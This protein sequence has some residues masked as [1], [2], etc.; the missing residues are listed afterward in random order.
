MGV[1]LR[2]DGDEREDAAAS[3]AAAIAAIYATA[4]LALLQV[5]TSAV[6]KALPLGAV[7]MAGLSQLRQRVATV[8]VAAE[9]RARQ[10][11]TSAGVPWDYQPVIPVSATTPPPAVPLPAETPTPGSGVP[12]EPS[13]LPDRG[14]APPSSPLASEPKTPADLRPSPEIAAAT[15]Q[16]TAP[17]IQDTIEALSARVYRQIPDLYQQAI[18]EAIA[19]TRGG[20]PQNSLSLSRIQAA[21]KALDELTDR[22]ITGFTD[23]TGKRWDLLGYVEMATRTAVSNAYDNLQNAALLRGGHDLIY[24]LTHSTEGSCP[25]CIPWLGKL[26][27]L[28]GQSSGTVTISD[29]GGQPVRVDVSGTLAEA[30]AAGFRHPNCRCS[31]IPFVNGADL[32]QSSMFAEPIDLAEATYR[33]SQVQRALERRVRRA[34]QHAATAMTPAARRRAEADLARARAASA[35]H[36]CA[37][38]LRMTKVGAHRREHPSD[39]H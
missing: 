20:M 18:A 36:R 13:G 7:T 9:Q 32:A 37:S 2:V 34:E 16:Q 11:I 22:G 21:Q 30:R 8:L 27:S 10:V 1:P 28:T 4:E 33:A 38:G 5:L 29:A 12:P 6:R 24:T 17:S 19:D 15:G 35:A 3:I 25:L 39:A 14:P 26:L 23:R 31:W